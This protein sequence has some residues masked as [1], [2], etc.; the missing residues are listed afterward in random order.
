MQE[1]SG[2]SLLLPSTKQAMRDFIV[3]K[4][5][6]ERPLKHDPIF[7]SIAR[8]LAYFDDVKIGQ[9]GSQH[10]EEAALR[11]FVSGR[12]D[13]LFW[14][15]GNLRRDE[16][17]TLLYRLGLR[18]GALP[19][20]GRT[21]PFFSDVA[22]GNA[23]FPAV[24]SLGSNGKINTSTGSYRPTDFETV[25]EFATKL[26]SIFELR[27]KLKNQPKK[28]EGQSTNAVHSE[29]MEILQA[30]FAPRLHPLTGEVFEGQAE[31]I[32]SMNLR[33]I[34]D[35]IT[36]GDAARWLVNTFQSL[37]DLDR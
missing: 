4:E 12:S 10:I 9:S 6:L 8:D 22:L 31:Q 14:P 5:L 36:R 25:G 24:Q 34:N 1:N 26:V 16:A 21:T 30:N 7:C 23:H 15:D 33:S 3:S 20:P 32:A 37:K 27:E 2:G 11:G 18:L 13:L 19:V 29:S 35:P 28:F 17:A